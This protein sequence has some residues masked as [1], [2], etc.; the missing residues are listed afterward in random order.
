VPD[1]YSTELYQ[2]FKEELIPILP[3]LLHKMETEGTLPNSFYKISVTLIFKPHKDPTK[4]EN[5][6]PI[7]LMNIDAT[8]LYDKSL[9]E[10]G[11]QGT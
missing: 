4:K 8:S 2:T 1:G 11:I 7:S 10:I 9:G 6:R 5:F 3:K